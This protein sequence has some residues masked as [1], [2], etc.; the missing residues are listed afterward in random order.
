[1]E[2]SY[3]IL[4]YL[5]GGLALLSIFGSISNGGIGPG[6]LFFVLVLIVLCA[7]FY[8]KSHKLQKKNKDVEVKDVKSPYVLYLRSFSADVVTSDTP[9]FITGERNE[10]ECLVKI[11]EQIAPV[12]AIGDPK[13]EKMPMGATRVYVDDDHWKSTVKELAYKAEA[14]VLRLGKTNSFWW[15]VE[16]VLKDIPL[17]KL[18]F[19]VPEAKSFN[20]VSMLYKLLIDKGVDIGNQKINVK[21]VKMGSLSSFLYFDENE[22]PYT[23]SVESPKVRM[24]KAYEEVLQKALVGFF[25]TYSATRKYNKVDS[26][27]LK[28][29]L[30]KQASEQIK[31]QKEE[32][33]AF[34]DV[35]QKKAKHMKNNVSDMTNRVKNSDAYNNTKDAIRKTGSR[36]GNKI[37]EFG[38]KMKNKFD[39]Q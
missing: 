19:A 35:V 39:N 28:E 15:E 36:I 37:A 4:A 25:K 29:R 23:A 17:R 2:K 27:E 31:Q 3:K 13:D 11:L 9:Y 16:M 26:E 30:A 7:F 6:V 22:K 8:K 18:L 20:E 34:T 21:D 12:Y 10:E 38:N 33:L 1:M 5:F 32:K 14:V 24:T